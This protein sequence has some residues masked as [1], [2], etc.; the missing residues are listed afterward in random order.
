MIESTEHKRIGVGFLKNMSQLDMVDHTC[1]PS[2]QEI[3]TGKS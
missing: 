2:T 3:E 1:N